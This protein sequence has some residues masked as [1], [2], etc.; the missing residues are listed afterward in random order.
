MHK[1]MNPDSKVGLPC[2]ERCG[3]NVLEA[4]AQAVNPQK[5]KICDRL[6]INNGKMRNIIDVDLWKNSGN[7]KCEDVKICKECLFE[8]ITKKTVQIG[9][10][11]LCKCPLCDNPVI[12]NNYVAF[13][14]QVMKEYEEHLRSPGCEAK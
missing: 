12:V 5:C 2:S 7:C 9:D 1:A 13:M 10:T 8:H 3:N 4:Y 11:H 6:F 14:D